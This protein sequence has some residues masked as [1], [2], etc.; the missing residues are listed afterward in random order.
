MPIM[1][2]KFANFL[3][4]FIRVVAFILKRQTFLYLNLFLTIGIKLGFKKKK[5]KILMVFI[6]INIFFL[7]QVEK[8]RKI[9]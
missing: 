7:N 3:L 1:F 2:H 5:K 4:F 6:P 8:K 9:T